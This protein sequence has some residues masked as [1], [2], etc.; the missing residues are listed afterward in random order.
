M[1]RIIGTHERATCPVLIALIIK[2]NIFDSVTVKVMYRGDNL[3]NMSRYINK[4]GPRLGKFWYHISI[5][6]FKTALNF[7][8]TKKVSQRSDESFIQSSIGMYHTEEK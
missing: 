3:I 8:S 1:D 7:Q 2:L 4:S 6:S 5:T